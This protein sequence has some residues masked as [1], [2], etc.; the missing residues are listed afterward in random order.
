MSVAPPGWGVS[1]NHLGVIRCCVE[2]VGAEVDGLVASFRTVTPLGTEA[3]DGVSVG[4]CVGLLVDRECTPV[5][6]SAGDS[7]PLAPRNSMGFLSD[8]FRDFAVLDVANIS[9][10]LLL[11]LSVGT[12]LRC[13]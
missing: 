2:D 12:R 11:G 5:F 6:F 4:V 1:G 3:A 9:E 8:I 13:Q 7:C 10:L